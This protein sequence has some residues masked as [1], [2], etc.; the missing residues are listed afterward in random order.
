MTLGLLF[1]LAACATGVA[2][3]S[4]RD[5]SN[6]LFSDLAPLLAL[7]GERV[8][9]QF[10]SHSMGWADNIIIAMAPLGIITIIVSAIRVGGPSWLK[11]LVGRARENIAVA[12]ADLMSSTSNEVCELW[13]GHHVVR[14][15]GS[16]PISEFIC[17]VPKHSDCNNVQEVRVISLDEALHKGYIKRRRASPTAGDKYTDERAN[18][19]III[20]HNQRDAAPNIS[21]NCH[22]QI[23]RGELYLVAIAATLLQSAVLVYSGFAACRLKLPKGKGANKDYAFPCTAVGMLLLVLGL[24]ICAHV[25]ETSTEEEMLCPMRGKAIRLVWLQQPKTVNDQVFDS[26]VLFPRQARSIITTSSRKDK[27]KLGPV[28]NSAS[29]QDSGVIHQTTIRVSVWFWVLKPLLVWS[30]AFVGSS[31]IVIMAALRALVRRGLARPPEDRLLDAG[32]ELE[33]FSLTQVDADKIWWPSSGADAKERDIFPDWRVI[34]AGS[35][36]VHSPLQKESEGSGIEDPEPL[37][38]AHQAMMIRKEL[39]HFVSWPAVA[40]VEAAALA[41]AIE[42]TMDALLCCSRCEKWKWSLKTHHVDSDGQSEVHFSL[43][44][45][46]AGGLESLTSEL[47]AALSLWLFSVNQYESEQEL[48]RGSDQ[49]PGISHYVKGPL[50]NSSL[51]LL[52]RYDKRLHRD[53]DWWMPHDAT[54]ILRVQAFDR[55]RNENTENDDTKRVLDV[56]N[57]R[58]VGCGSTTSPALSGESRYQCSPLPKF[59]K[60][61]KP[62]TSPKTEGSLRTYLAAEVSIPLKLL[63]AQELFAAFIWSVAKAMPSCIPGGSDLLHNEKADWKSFKFSHEELSRLVQDVSNTGLGTVD[64]IYL[65]MIPPLSAEN[66]LPETTEIIHLAKEQ[67]KRSQAKQD[68]MRARKPYLW[69]FEI[70]QTFPKDSAINVRTIAALLEYARVMTQALDLREPMGVRSEFDDEGEAQDPLAKAKAIIEDKIK[71]WLGPNEDLKTRTIF[72]YLRT[73]Y[74]EQGRGWRWE[75]AQEPN[76]TPV[77]AAGYP[78]AFGFDGLHRLYQKSTQAIYREIKAALS[79]GQTVDKQDVFSWTPLHYAAA[80]GNPGAAR[81]LLHNEADV[82]ARDLVDWTPLHYACQRGNTRVVHE[83]LQAHADLNLFG[84]DGVTPFHCAAMGGCT[85]AARSLL[86]AGAAP[87][88]T[89]NAGNTWLHWAAYHGRAKFMVDMK[90]EGE[91][92]LRNNNGRSPLHIASASG[93]DAV[94]KFLTANGDN[95][96]TECGPHNNPRLSL[97]PDLTGLDSPIAL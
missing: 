32:F 96:E 94:V 24:L 12:E 2:A 77:T 97:S 64:Q 28:A 11:A 93:H 62:E 35:S 59:G 76:P 29:S 73:L 38:K 46:D 13:N 20:I 44:P 79:Q 27:V 19:K 81:R 86:R 75:T 69:L 80:K 67:A 36:D 18:A 53:L 91:I 74:Q 83:L 49:I 30:S 10:M 54:R 39:G 56:Q 95:I 41:R 60:R 21:L 65:C 15:M 88:T 63:Y 23:C 89:D 72:S 37:S 17:L 52:G 7:F 85:D 78:Q 66:K 34:S 14:C 47:E 8:T 55:T 48:D 90:P 4:G 84:V 71:D 70:A 61:Q 6:D 1:A 50:S 22:G 3:E 92:N 43:R 5:F 40:S 51:R 87:D 82:N 25:V 33:W 9:M 45:G 16:A 42:I 31:F 68:W 26:Y 58:I 57:H